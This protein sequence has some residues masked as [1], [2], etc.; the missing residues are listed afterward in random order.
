[1][2]G[3]YAHRATARTMASMVNDDG[4]LIGILACDH[5]SPELREASRERDYD[6]MRIRLKA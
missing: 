5:V 4:P 2:H 3:S 1:M 6:D